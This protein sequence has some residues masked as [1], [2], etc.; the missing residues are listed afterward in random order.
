MKRGRG[1]LRRGVLT[2]CVPFSSPTSS[3]STAA[4]T[5]D[6]ARGAYTQTATATSGTDLQRTGN[7]LT[8]DYQSSTSSASTST[9]HKTGQDSSTTYDQ[10]QT[11][12]ASSDQQETGNSVT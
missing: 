10:S 1:S 4:G 6:D 2:S 5:G 3:T 9:V 12:S 11:D 8:G 7:D